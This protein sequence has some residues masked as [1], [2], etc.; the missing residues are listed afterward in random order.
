MKDHVIIMLTSYAQV[1]FYV[2]QLK[3]LLYGCALAAEN[4]DVERIALVE[5]WGG[6]GGMGRR[7]RYGEEVEVW[8]GDMEVW[9]GGVDRRILC[10]QPSVLH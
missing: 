1:K 9:G 7:W 10:V 6:G 8:G 2:P 3:R 5:V 4:S